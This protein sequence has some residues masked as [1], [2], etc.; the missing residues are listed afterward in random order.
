MSKKTML[1]VR[2]NE[3]VADETNV[4]EDVGDVSGLAQSIQSQ[5]GLIQPIT[6]R[7]DGDHYV[8]VAGHR[9]VAALNQLGWREPIP[10]LVHE[11]NGASSKVAQLTENLQRLDLTYW[12]EADGY[13]QLKIE[14]GMAQKDIARMVGVDAGTVSKRLTIAQLSPAARTAILQASPDMGLEV[15][16]EKARLLGKVP[17]EVWA[18]IDSA[19]KLK[20][21]E[22]AQRQVANV[23]RAKRAVS[24]LA[25]EAGNGRTIQYVERLNEF[26]IPPK[27]GKIGSLVIDA[28]VDGYFPGI[29]VNDD[30]SALPV[31][32]TTAVCHVPSHNMVRTYSIQYQDEAALEAELRALKKKQKKK[33]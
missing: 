7:P 19:T 2:L 17:D 4:R 3:L 8:I 24:K 20:R 23:A 29:N 21:L 11:N 30:L 12:E 9:R 10:A 28:P 31:K 16:L 14:Y 18:T 33:K 6:I 26:E 5:G 27:K 22:D 32:K 25:K 15:A 13:N 1:F